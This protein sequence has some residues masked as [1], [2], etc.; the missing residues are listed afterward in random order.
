MLEAASDEEIADTVAVMGGV[1]FIVRPKDVRMTLAPSSCAI[2]ATWKAIEE[3]IR[4][5]VTSRVLPSR[6]MSCLS[7]AGFLSMPRR[8]G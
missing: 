2:R 7:Y 5:P 3:S 6:S 8:A 4:T 1:I